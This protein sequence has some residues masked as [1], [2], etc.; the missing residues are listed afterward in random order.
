[1]VRIVGGL[2]NQMFQYAFGLS[3]SRL[4]RSQL[5]LDCRDFDETSIHNG[6]ELGRVFGVP[7]PCGSS[8]EIRRCFGWR[9][10]RTAIKLLSNPRFARFRGSY[11]LIE[12]SSTSVEKARSMGPHCYVSGFWQNEAFFADCAPTVRKMFTFKSEMSQDNRDTAYQIE[13]G[14]SVS[15]HVRRGDYITNTRANQSHGTCSVQYYNEAMAYIR[16]VEHNPEFF[17]FSDDPEWAAANIGDRSGN[18]Y[19]VTWNTGPES[20]N[21]MR[22]MSLCKHHIIANSSF[23]WWGA[24]L[25]EHSDGC[26]IAPARWFRQ[27]RKRDPVP[28]RWIRI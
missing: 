14:A 7:Q 15:V 3:L 4:Y 27:A 21:D 13:R 11:I 9:G 10:T 20:F 6:F 18:C 1:M 12:D 16:E 24:W 5:L 25:A 17:I 19:H 22:L 8:S 2:G 28:I 26:V 23:S